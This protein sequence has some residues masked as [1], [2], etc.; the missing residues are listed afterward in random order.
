MVGIN[1]DRRARL[2]SLHGTSLTTSYQ[3]EQFEQLVLPHMDA[4]YNLARWLV[5]NPHD[6]EDRRAGSD[7]ARH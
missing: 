7:D 4:A 5:R 2:K 6:A 1:R 3:R